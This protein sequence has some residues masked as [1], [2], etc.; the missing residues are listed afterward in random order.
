MIAGTPKTNKH[1]LAE[2]LWLLYFNDVLYRDGI[3]TKENYHKM[4]YCI[5][6]RNKMYEGAKEKKQY[7]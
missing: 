7:G 1:L 4:I 2:N 5:N 6:S 3:I